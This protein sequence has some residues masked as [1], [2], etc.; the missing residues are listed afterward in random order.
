MRAGLLLLPAT[1]AAMLGWDWRCSFCH[2]SAAALISYNK[3]GQSQER[4]LGL[5]TQGCR[6]LDLYP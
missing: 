1:A 6:L 3:H 5:V 2:W 4:A